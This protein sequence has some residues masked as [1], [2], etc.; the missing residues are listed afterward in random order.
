METVKIKCKICNQLVEAKEMGKAN[1]G[2][3]TYEI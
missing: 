3:N 2:N 1:L